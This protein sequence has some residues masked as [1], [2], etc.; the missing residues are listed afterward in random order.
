MMPGVAKTLD[1]WLADPAIR[2]THRRHSTADPD[3]LWAMD[4][5]ANLEGTGRLL[6][7]PPGIPPARLA[8]LRAAVKE[9][10]HI[11]QLLAEG[12]K[13]E[14]IRKDPFLGPR[15]AALTPTLESFAMIQFTWPNG[16]PMTRPVHLIGIDPD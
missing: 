9:T 11:P 4:F 6:I 1:D 7:A 2:V 13:M 5:L 14:R 3:R 8:Y 12:E 10:L 15:I 16:E